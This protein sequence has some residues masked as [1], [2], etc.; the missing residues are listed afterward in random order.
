MDNPVPDQ[1]E[2]PQK[3]FKYRL[4]HL[5]VVMTVLAILLATLS[6]L[7]AVSIVPILAIGFVSL[8]IYSI[9][10]SDP[11]PFV[12]GTIVVVAIALVFFLIPTA[13]GPIAPSKRSRCQMHLRQIA[14]AMREY[15]DE[16]GSYPPP[17]IADKNGKPMHS[18]RA[19]IYSRMDTGDTDFRTRYRFDEPWDGPN[20]RKLAAEYANRTIFSCPGEN[21]PSFP[22]ETSYVVVVGPRTMFSANRRVSDKDIKDNRANT[23]ML[24]EVHHSGIHWME[25]RDLHVLQM[26]PVVNPKIGQGISSAHGAG[27]NIATA[28]GGTCYLDGESLTPEMLHG[29]LSIDGGERANIP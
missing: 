21:S 20:N 25:P 22:G 23:I 14:I 18:W 26:S 15:H 27:A 1:A 28:D 19:I 24:V 9:V 3:P 10:R 4:W 2:L 12:I 5:F 6:Q 29:L 11:S 13:M 8:A 7:G 16:F 17:Y